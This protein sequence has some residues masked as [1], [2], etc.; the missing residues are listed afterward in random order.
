M[1]GICLQFFES[2]TTEL[3]LHENDR[4]MSHEELLRDLMTVREKA[5]ELW[6]K[7]GNSLFTCL[8]VCLFVCLNDRKRSHEELL[9]D[10]M[11]M[12][13]EELLKDL[14]TVREKAQELWDK[15]D[16]NSQE[17]ATFHQETSGQFHVTL[18]NLRQMNATVN[19]LLHLMDSMKTGLDKRMD[20][21]A[22]SLG[23]AG[24][25]MKTGLDK[26][27][28]FLAVS[29]GG[30]GEWSFLIALVLH[31]MD[32]MKTGLDKRM[33]FLA[34]SLGGA[35]DHLA[36]LASCVLHVGYFL[37]AMVT[38]TF[39]QSPALS[40][41]VMLVLVPTNA[42]SEVRYR[43]SLDFQSLTV[44]LTI[45]VVGNWLLIWL[46]QYLWPRCRDMPS[47]IRTLCSC[48][49]TGSL[50]PPPTII[51]S[52]SPC[53]KP[54]RETQP[55]FSED[56]TSPVKLESDMQQII[57]DSIKTLEMADR[58]LLQVHNTSVLLNK[59][60]EE[61]TDGFLEE[62]IISVG[63]TPVKPPN[64]PRGLSSTPMANNM[65]FGAGRQ[66]SVD[67][68]VST[69][70]IRAG[71]TTNIPCPGTPQSAR[72]ELVKRHLGSVLEDVS[73]SPRRSPRNSPSHPR[74]PTHTL[75]S[76]AS[77]TPSKANRRT[78]STPRKYCK[79]ITKAGAQCRVLCASDKDY[80]HVHA[81]NFSPAR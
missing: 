8:F 30:A 32:S 68:R 13:H 74:T 36:V 72:K 54:K 52:P 42:V 58:T 33:D 47:P 71:L 12:S 53:R 43:R 37:V 17:M 34:V 28:D 57:Q 55:M 27:M 48:P 40:R 73:M 46:A 20:F 38:M 25:C 65:S 14:M 5:Q 19:Y 49:R 23:G 50:P 62:S 11:T 15:I 4:K 79:G 70:H 81:P 77:G 63:G 24:E 64:I 59:S 35:G 76:S 18:A 61:R 3:L 60:F 1:L 41:A 44:L 51:T 2:A 66:M 6:D 7:I 78:P 21:L 22:V 10:L 75:N 80:C 9:K 26:R 56:E 31:L 16:H 67:V 69:P 45:T 29:L 39:L